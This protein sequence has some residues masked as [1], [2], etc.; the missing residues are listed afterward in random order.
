MVFLS[1]R[2]GLRLIPTPGRSLN[3]YLR[4]NKTIIAGSSLGNF[5]QQ[6]RSYQSDNM[7]APQDI[8]LPGMTAPHQASKP[9]KFI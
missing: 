5:Q 4:N 6:R 3:R 7:S 1:A 8:R 9:G 2:L